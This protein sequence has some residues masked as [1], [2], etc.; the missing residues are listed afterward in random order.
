[1]QALRDKQIERI[2]Q[3]T[4]SH[5]IYCRHLIDWNLLNHTLTDTRELETTVA[6]QATEIE[7]ATKLIE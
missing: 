1:M 7:I 4:L 2:F 6:E 5:V 3:I